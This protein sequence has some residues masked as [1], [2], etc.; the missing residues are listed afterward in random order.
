MRVIEYLKKFSDINEGLK[1]LETEFGITNKLYEDR[2]VLNYDQI[3]SHKHRF[4]PIVRECRALILS[5][6]TLNI[7]CRSFDRFFDHGKDKEDFDITKSYCTIKIDGSLINVYHDGIRWQC[8]T[9]K[10]AFAEGTVFSNNDKTFR[11][12]FEEV[13]GTSVDE[14]FKNWA[15][16]KYTYIFELVS[17]ETRIINRYPKTAI[18]G[19]AIRNKYNGN[20][21]N[22]YEAAEIFEKHLPM[23]NPYV[24]GPTF[25]NIDEI[26][27]SLKSLPSL[28]ETFEGYVF[29]Y[30]D[31]HGGQTRL[32]IKNPAYLAFSNLRC[33]GQLNPKSIIKIVLSCNEDEYLASFPEDKPYFEKYIESRQ[34]MYDSINKLSETTMHIQD[35]KEFALKVKDTPISS[36]MFMLRKGNELG[37]II[38]NMSD[39]GKITLF[40]RLEKERGKHVS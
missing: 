14:M 19:I 32:K 28:G 33:N 34:Y 10:M 27:E 1:N 21:L 30:D 29:V 9:R 13:L 40:E 2:V 39:N 20:Y 18:H 37:K 5:I 16:I 15:D 22:Y 3:E 6:P 17:P 11:M 31:G 38:D 24:K 23:I 4:N 7:L 12:L 36:I 26:L 35:Q 8:S 25:K